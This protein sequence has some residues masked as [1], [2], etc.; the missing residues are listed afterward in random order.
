MFKTKVKKKLEKIKYFSYEIIHSNRI[1]RLKLNIFCDEIHKMKLSNWFIKWKYEWK[2]EKKNFSTL[3]I[4]FHMLCVESEKNYVSFRFV[5]HK[6]K[7]RKFICIKCVYYSYI[8]LN[9]NSMQFL[10][11]IYIYIYI[12]VL[13]NL[14][15]NKKH[16]L[17]HW[18]KKYLYFIKWVIFIVAV[19]RLL[20]SVS[21]LFF[22]LA[23]N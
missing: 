20:W 23:L 10:I 2:E 6:Q 22:F 1:H 14:F 21:F 3:I 12:C 5:K 4:P 13:F 9:W 8:S 15:V 19:I 11:C 18:L 16:T 7:V 17:T